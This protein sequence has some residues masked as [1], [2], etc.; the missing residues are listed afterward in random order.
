MLRLG[1]L[2]LFIA[3][4]QVYID[5]HQ[6]LAGPMIKTNAKTIKAS[7]QP[8]T[9]YHRAARKENGLRIKSANIVTSQTLSKQS[10]AAEGTRE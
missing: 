9:A 1:F 10:I 6:F 5:A 4:Q 3:M 7:P 2:F 8:T